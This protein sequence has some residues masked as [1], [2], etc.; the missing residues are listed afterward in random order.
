M[1]SFMA[2]PRT[3]VQISTYLQPEEADRVRLAA[4]DDGRSVSNYVGEVLT[5]EAKLDAVYRDW[6]GGMPPGQRRLWRDLIG[7]TIRHTLPGE[8]RGEVALTIAEL[9]H[10]GHL[11]I[12]RTPK[13]TL[14]LE[15]TEAGRAEANAMNGHGASI[16]AAAEP[17]KDEGA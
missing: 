3:T 12:V 4:Q 17:H 9:E 1:E 14:R 7:S 5:R 15:I 16:V 8:S 10:L 6:I 13:G 11:R 2:E